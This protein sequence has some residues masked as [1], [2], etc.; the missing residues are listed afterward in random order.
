MSYLLYC[1]FRSRPVPM[2]GNLTG[3]AGQPVVLVGTNGISAAVS[4]LSHSNPAPDFSHLL[5]Y[6]NVIASFHRDRTLIPMRYG[7]LLK[8]EK[9][10]VRL[11]DENRA[12]Y[13][14]LMEELDN[15]VEMG[16]RILIEYEINAESGARNPD[17]KN[18]DPPSAARHPHSPPPG[19]T[20][21]SAR[22]THY[23]REDEFKREIESTI[24]RCREMF[25][26]L[27]RKIRAEHGPPGNSQTSV[28]SFQP[29]HH[30]RQ[31]HNRLLS[32]YF[33]VPRQSVER[34]RRVFRRFCSAKEAKLLLS[35]PWPP[36]NFVVPDRFPDAPARSLQDS[37]IK[38]HR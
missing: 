4:G 14:A 7:C 17:L 29:Q 20:Y 31:S 13:V 23:D 36:Y 16:I 1:I 2:T 12:Q 26:G 24:D 6:K 25:S 21:L 9:R 8:E 27:Y 3:V 35:G 38:A 34:F 19:R 10:V 15:C 37:N 30:N 22:K 28:F 11:L 33:L 18:P 5:A 32:I